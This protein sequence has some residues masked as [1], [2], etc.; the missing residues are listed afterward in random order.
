MKPLVEALAKDKRLDKGRMFS[1]SA[2]L[3]SESRESLQQSIQHT[4]RCFLKKKGLKPRLGQKQ[5]IAMVANHLAQIP[6]NDKK[7]RNEGLPVCMVE[8][9]TGTGKTLAY[10][11]GAV[12]YARSHNKSLIVSTA[13]VALQEQLIEKDL[14][15][16]NELLDF[17]VDCVLVKG[18][19]RYLCLNKLDGLLL[20]NRKHQASLD[21]F[22]AL[23][24]NDNETLLLN[25]LFEAVSSGQWS[26][27]ID[28]W[29]EEIPRNLW[30]KVTATHRECTNRSCRFFDHCPFYLARNQ[31][32]QA[33]VLVTNHDL[34]LSDLALGGGT[35]LPTPEES[36]FVFDEAHHLPD[37]ALQHFS[38]SF[39][40]NRGIVWLKQ[41]EQMLSAVSTQLGVP[42]VLEKA[43]A[44]LPKLSEKITETIKSS[45]QHLEQLRAYAEEGVYRFPNG[46]TPDFLVEIAQ[47]SV[48]QLIN[49][50]NLLS[51]VIESLKESS[52]KKEALFPKDDAEFWLPLAGQLLA[53]FESAY[54]LWASFAKKDEDNVPPIARWISWLDSQEDLGL[55]SSPI[56]AA[57]S[58]KEQLWNR[59][60]AAITTSATL[61]ALN[62]FERFQSQVGIESL[63]SNS[64]QA[65]SP[66]KFSENASLTILD[67]GNPNQYERHTKNIVKALPKLIEDKEAVLVLFASR[68]QLQA[69]LEASRDYLPILAQHELSKNSILKKHKERLDQGLGSVIFGLASFSEG[70]DLP[71]KYLS[72]VIIAKLPFA[73]PNDP[74]EA[75]QAEW[76]ERRGGNPFKEITLPDA[77]VKLVQACGRLL[78]TEEDFGRISILDGRLNSKYYGRVLLQALPPYTLRQSRYLGI[79]EN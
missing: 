22:D 71:G 8:A 43:F 55:A 75:S 52:I 54:Q 41:L 14:P 6:L 68:R 39:Y 36:I 47:V 37:K 34:V 58:L 59:C 7:Q 57:K 10:L 23:M 16:L 79:Y 1:S 40:L 18:R 42:K 64:L 28:T 70:I 5:M 49:L 46:V 24:P 20:D 31:V 62:S 27:E 11:L 69:V 63:V 9:G 29:P 66:F 65:P 72:H 33:D 35:L 38:N 32:D 44:Q 50:I 4:Y 76:V 48:V 17:D 51:Q 74:I 15:E 60:F 13:T 61:T 19:G 26:G 45:N 56:C 30:S 77:S 78:R 25:R 2:S 53:R 67:L 12:F 21:L 3:D 73:V